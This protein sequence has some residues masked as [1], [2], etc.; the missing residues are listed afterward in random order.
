M[1]LTH[2]FSVPASVDV[3]WNTF[4]D[5]REVGECFPG[6]T[7]TEVSGDSFTGQVKVKLGPIAMVYH[8]TG[9]FTERD[10][11]SHHAVIKAEGKDKRGNGTAGA[12]ATIAL[13]PDG[14]DKTQVDVT[15]DLLVTGKPAQFGR[16]VM[17]DVSDKLL[18][19]FVQCIEG[20]LSA[21]GG[22][23]GAGASSSSS[24]KTA[25]EKD[26][27]KLASSSSGSG[28]GASAPRGPVGTA[29]MFGATAGADSWEKKYAPSAAGSG[30]SGG[31]ASPGSASTKADSA[32]ASAP[33]AARPTPTPA[34]RPAPAADDDALDLGSAVLPVLLKSNAKP[35]AIGVVAFLIGWKLARKLPG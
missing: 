10:D 3:A 20:K 18:G 26:G 34:Y 15:T 30:G 24:G 5:L 8:G 1:Q 29:A 19:Q 35:I 2:S 9:H 21:G 13:S 33:S 23:G 11:D 16:G 32:S 12:T 4:M 14:V 22:G 7:V 6:A 28:G 27:P 25:A 31:A 17:Q